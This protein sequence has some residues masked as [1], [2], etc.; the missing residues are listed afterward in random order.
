MPNIWKRRNDTDMPVPASESDSGLILETRALSEFKWTGYQFISLIGRAQSRVYR[1]KSLKYDKIFAAKV[2]AEN[3]GDAS[4]EYSAS[5]ELDAMRALM[6][7]NII[8]CYDAFSDGRRSVL[9]IEHCSGG[10]LE[11][12]IHEEGE[13]SGL[14]TSV[15]LSVASQLIDALAF[16]HE[17]GWAHRDVKPSNVL[18]ADSMRRTLR[19]IDFGHA[20]R[21]RLSRGPAGTPGFRPPEMFAGGEYDPQAA[22]VFALGVT[23]RRVVQGPPWVAEPV[24]ENFTQMRT[25]EPVVRCQHEGLALAIRRMLAPADSRATMA[26]LRQLPLSKGPEIRR[27]RS[28]RAGAPAGSRKSLPVGTIYSDGNPLVPD[29]A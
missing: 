29:F 8:C 2:L 3:P 25:L 16:M 5:I 12:L 4:G 13:G 10:S 9:I 14:G 7:P 15:A 1:V 23:L 27:R 17:H 24:G 6:H 11:E 19:L 22:D 18:F 28:L 21:K 26:E 20:T